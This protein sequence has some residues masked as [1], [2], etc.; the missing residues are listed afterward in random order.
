MP[1]RLGADHDGDDIWVPD[2]SAQNVLRINIHT[3]QTTL[4]DAPLPNLRPYMAVVDNS[5]NVW[6]NLLGSDDFVKFDPQNSQWTFYSWPNRGTSTRG[7]AVLDRGG[8]V[9]VSA[10]FFNGSTVA[11]AVFRTK[12]DVD[13]L[14]DGR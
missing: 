8:V 6:M 3:L 10:A 9:Q 12:Q 11:K 7:F 13:A 2:N 14:E 4:F 1:R 5:H